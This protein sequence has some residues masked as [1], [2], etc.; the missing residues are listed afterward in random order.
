[1]KKITESKIDPEIGV[2]HKGE[3][4]K[5]FAYAAQTACDKN[6]HV[7]DVTVNAGNVNDGVAFDGLYERLKKRLAMRYVVA[8]A[9]YRT[10]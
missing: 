7:L 4:K 9:D 5:C 6:G 10:P 8:D 1:M 3:H 2:F